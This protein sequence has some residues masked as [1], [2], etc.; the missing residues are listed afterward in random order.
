MKIFNIE[1]MEAQVPASEQPT[2]SEQFSIVEE[3]KR[4][5]D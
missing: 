4:R 5:F 2:V 1:G 3:E